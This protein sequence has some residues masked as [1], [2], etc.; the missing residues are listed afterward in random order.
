M[1]IAKPSIETALKLIGCVCVY[2]CVCVCVCVCVCPARTS[3]HL[4]SKSC[5]LQISHMYCYIPSSHMTRKFGNLCCK[6]LMIRPTS[7][8]S[9]LLP[10]QT[11]SR[12]SSLTNLY[13]FSHSIHYVSI[14]I[15]ITS[16][17]FVC[18]E[19]NQE[20]SPDKIHHWGW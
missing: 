5:W 11:K 20:C 8:E 19:N 16:K 6:L 2:M 14:E 4:A 9:Y 12:K 17:N 1:H 15:N 3:A 13:T 7:E 10:A 18:R